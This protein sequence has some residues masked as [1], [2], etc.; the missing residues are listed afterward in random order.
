VNNEV[1]KVLFI[2]NKFS[3]GGFHPA[4]EGKIIDACEQ[5]NLESTIEFTR[6]RGH[7]TELA[8]SAVEKK[9]F[10]LVVAVGGDGTVNE[11]ANG[12]VHSPVPMAILPKGSG[13]GLARHL[14]IPMDIP[15]AIQT[16]FKSQ[17]IAMDTFTLNGKLS[18]N[19]SGIGFDGHVANLFKDSTKRGLQGYAKVTLN[20]FVRFKEF[21]ADITMAEKSLTR[22]GFIIAI[23][24]SS[25]YGNN[26]R[27]APAASVCDEL[28]HV[29][30]LK[31]VPAYRLDF[32]YNFFAGKIEDTSFCEIME[33][34]NMTIKVNTP[35]AFHI[36]GEPCGVDTQ[37][38]IEILPA[39]LKMMVPVSSLKY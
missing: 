15:K 5:H 20:E 23:A 11:V 17:I 30:F 21:E 14:G 29:C 33:S 34:R 35:V 28:L 4:F 27:I 22:K 12:L 13:N 1:K 36:D 26:A 7:A 10:D 24:N 2:I 38:R 25:Q 18:L 37:F 39:S 3:G 16:L 6:S 8:R 19:V 31:K 32:I 9:N